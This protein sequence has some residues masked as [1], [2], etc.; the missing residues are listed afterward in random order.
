MG[1]CGDELAEERVELSGGDTRLPAFEGGVEGTHDAV[2]VPSGLRS[3]VDARCPLDLNQFALELVLDLLLALL[4]NEVPL[5]GDDDER[6][7]R[8]DD[9]LNDTHVLLGQR[10]RTI[11]EDEGDLG[12]LDRGLGADGGVV[13]GARRPVHLAADTCGVDEPPRAAV[14]L[15]E[16]IDGVTGGTG[17]LIDDDAL[18]PGQRIE[19]G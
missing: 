13:V 18:A 3:Q 19:Q 6:A 17:E 12:L 5:V 11:D 1:V 15:D 16:L 9:L 14:E 2:G 7:A 8:V 4:V 10:C